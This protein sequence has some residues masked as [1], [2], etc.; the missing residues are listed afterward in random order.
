[1]RTSVGTDRSDFSCTLSWVLG[2]FERVRH[3]GFLEVAVGEDDLDRG[4]VER[5]IGERSEVMCRDTMRRDTI[6]EKESEEQVEEM[7]W[8]GR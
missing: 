3:V 8:C 7:G 2:E 5:D 1:M 6:Q 4:S